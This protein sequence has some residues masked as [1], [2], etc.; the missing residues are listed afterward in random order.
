MCIYMYVERHSLPTMHPTRRSWCGREPTEDGKSF[1]CTTTSVLLVATTISI[2]GVRAIGLSACYITQE[3]E[4]R[5][6]ASCAPWRCKFPHCSWKPGLN[7]LPRS[8]LIAVLCGGELIT[9][10]PTNKM[11]SRGRV[12]LEFKLYYWCS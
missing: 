11:S 4:K 8:S 2:F 1:V 10:E 6:S 7:L 5:P 12:G 9:R 3:G